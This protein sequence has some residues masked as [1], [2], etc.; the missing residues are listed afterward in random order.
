[1]ANTEVARAEVILNGQKA[2]ATLKELEN[3]AKALNAELRKLPTNSAE[4]TKKT[5]EFQ[6]VKGRLNEV[7]QEIIGTQG[8][9][10]KFADWTN[11]YFQG[12]TLVAAAFTGLGMAI[13]AMVKNAG[14]LEDS[15]ANMRKTTGMTA[16]EVKNLNS[17]FK[18]IDTRTSREELRNIAIVAGQLGIEKESIFS[19]TDSIDKLNVAL[20]DE[21]AGGAEG[22]ASTMGTLRNVLTDLKTT[23]VSDDLLRLGNA[24][25][26]LSASGL[27]TAPVLADFAN[28]IGG[29][30]I[31]LG[32]SSDEVLGMSATMQELAINTER[33]GT[34]IVKILS[35]MTTNTG[36]FAKVAGLP[37]EEFTRMV[38]TDLYGALSRF[39]KVL[40]TGEKV[41]PFWEE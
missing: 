38:D 12:I 14:D 1:M 9:M 33:G 28:R 39:W 35:K 22:V 5:E 34:A 15:L 21:L 26:D 24:I 29:V 16:D 18:K 13:G 4:F 25:N 8:A 20:G 27:A 31:N 41:Q 2:N 36:E 30:G 19:F 3:S 7:K 11:K 17:E 40:K 10:S 6:K 23:N 37:L 32:L